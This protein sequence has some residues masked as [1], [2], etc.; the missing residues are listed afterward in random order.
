MF[1]GMPFA[2][3]P[4]VQR[5][6]GLM[7]VK[8][9]T[10]FLPPGDYRITAMLG[11]EGGAGTVELQVRAYKSDTVLATL[12]SSAPTQTVGPT[13]AGDIV[14]DQQNT[15]IELWANTSNNVCRGVVDSIGISAA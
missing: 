14:L 3:T 4:D 12:T 1:D 9:A 8:I 2:V 11:R 6:S 7:F 10:V 5:F 13:T 15:A